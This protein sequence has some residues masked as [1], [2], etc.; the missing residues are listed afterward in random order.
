MYF[1]TLTFDQKDAREFVRN[2]PTYNRAKMQGK[3]EK[4]E[5]YI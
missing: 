5:I 1:M 2:N 3:T 4:I